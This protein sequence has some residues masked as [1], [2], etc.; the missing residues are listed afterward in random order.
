MAAQP[1]PSKTS[2]DELSTP[3]IRVRYPEFSRLLRD[4]ISQLVPQGELARHQLDDQIMTSPGDDADA[5][6]IDVQADYF[7]NRANANHD[8]LVEIRDAVDRMHR[9]VYGMCENCG[10]SISLQR[11]RTLP[12]ARNCI[13]CQSERERSRIVAFPQAKPKL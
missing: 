4:R 13:G 6:E 7:L 12:A 11:L 8:E 10:Q 9:G 1:K 5:A 2:T 3:E